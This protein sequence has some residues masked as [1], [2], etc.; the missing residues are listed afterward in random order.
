MIRIRP[1]KYEKFDMMMSPNWQSLDKLLFFFLKFMD[2]FLIKHAIRVW[3]LMSIIVG[4]LNSLKQTILTIR[5]FPIKEL[6]NL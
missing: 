4:Y 5:R 3:L 2:I 1:F 6:K